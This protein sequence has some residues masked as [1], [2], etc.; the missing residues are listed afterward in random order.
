M[1]DSM[2]PRIVLLPLV[3]VT[4]GGAPNAESSRT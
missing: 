2:R 4:A 3:A 1:R